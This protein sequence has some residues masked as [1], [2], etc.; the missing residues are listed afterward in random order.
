MEKNKD[1]GVE[2]SHTIC[3]NMIVKN[4]SHIIV[5]TLE[6]LIKK[7]RID[8]WVISD[9]GSTDNT[10][11]LIK[12]FFKQRNIPGELVEHEW[13][14]FGYNRTQALEC[15]Y[16]KTDYLLIFDADDE[17]CGD[18]VLPKNL[19]MDGYRLNFGNENGVSYVRV[20]LV[21]NRKKWCYKCVLH[22][23]IECLEP[24]C[25]YETI[26]GNYY[27]IS[28]RKGARSMDPEKYLKDAIILEKAHAKALEEND[29][30]YI[31]YAFYCANSYNDCQKTEKAIEW[32]KITLS[33][34]NWV[35]EKY[36][37]CLRLYECMEKLKREEE[38][39]FYL[40]E[41]R[42]YDKVRVECIFNLVKYYCVHD[43]SDMSY[44][45]YSLIKNWYE[46]EFLKT[47]DFSG[48]LFLSIGVYNFFMAYFMIIVYS[49]MNK[50]EE[51]LVMFEIITNKKYVDCSDW[52]I[53]NVFHNFKLY[54]PAFL[55]VNWSNERKITFL[56]NFLNYI[57]LIKENNMN[58]KE[59]IYKT[60]QELIDKFRPVLTTYKTNQVLKSKKTN[61]K[62]FLSITTCKRLDL[63]KQ[64]VNSIMNTWLDIDKVDYFLCVDDNSSVKDQEYMKTK[65]PFFKF[66]LKTPEEKGH[67]SSMN[68]IWNKL[69]KLK[70]TYW[71][72]LEDDWLFFKQ[73]YYV[74]RSINVLEKYTNQNVHQ[75]LFNRNY[76]ELYTGWTIN[77]GKK[78]GP[79]TVIHEKRDDIV[80]QNCAY[81]PH[82]SFR[83]SMVNVKTIMNLGNYNSPNNFF[84]RDYADRYF[85]RGFR[86]A[87][88][89]GVCSQHIGKLTSDKTGTN[90]YTLNQLDQ[91][92]VSSEQ[93]IEHQGV[94]IKEQLI[95][96]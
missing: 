7:I 26:V 44:L 16:D 70:P 65:Y 49:K 39:M 69:R 23:F 18:F 38:G 89:N 3:L 80:G 68:I 34:P 42:K 54:V 72:H 94:S 47:T 67:R 55:S 50:H 88:F 62:V 21:N 61:I 19:D 82:Y 45:Y 29:D 30:L 6:K 83:P 32:Y 53:N 95:S 5:E 36:I 92:N 20:L 22:E 15:A 28:G 46:N 8:Y 73:D 59:D 12:T 57:E 24:V 63:F 58:V 84:E 78:I 93:R 25:K 40:I 10:K 9:T 90:A 31:R 4:E 60:V 14:D 51:G 1:S 48:F 77:G 86:S 79:N 2:K 87:F 64:T 74:Q 76:A 96:T 56:T 33:Q 91:F 66:Y 37:S 75:I 13:R 11:E 81:W 52:F 43:M 41:S 71:I 85:D 35:Q 27:V 17:L